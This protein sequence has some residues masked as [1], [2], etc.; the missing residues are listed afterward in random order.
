MFRA[1]PLFVFAAVVAAMGLGACA[2]DAT[3]PTTG[4]SDAGGS[5]EA[6]AGASNP[7]GAGDT[8]TAGVADTTASPGD[9]TSSGRPAPAFLVCTAQPYAANSA[10]IGPKGGEIKVGK[11]EFKVPKGALNQLTLIT[12]EV[13]SDTV[14]SVRFSPEGLTFNPGKWPELKLD[15]NNCPKQPKNK[16]KGKGEDKV[17]VG[18][19]TEDLEVI[20]QLPSADDEFNEAVQTHLKHFS[21]YA[22]TY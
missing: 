2:N 15:Y 21:R 22:I 10:W 4:A 14:K 17:R 20:Q 18:Y 12:M 3:A 13:P 8:T 7:A 19:V 9:T 16:G 6:G 11:N 1:R 5:T